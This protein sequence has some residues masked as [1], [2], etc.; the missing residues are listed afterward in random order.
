LL[1]SLS[2][3]IATPPQKIGGSAAAQRGPERNIFAR[4]RRHFPGRVFKSRQLPSLP[5]ADDRKTKS[6]EAD[7]DRTRH[8]AGASGPGEVRAAGLIY[9]KWP[10][11]NIR[12]PPG[13]KI[14]CF[15]KCPSAPVIL[16]FALVSRA[17]ESKLLFRQR[18]K[19]VVAGRAHVPYP[20]PR[21]CRLGSLSK[22]DSDQAR[23]QQD[24]T[25]NGHGE[26]TIRGEFF[27]H[28]APP[29]A[30]ECWLP[31]RPIARPT[32]R[33]RLSRCTVKEISTLFRRSESN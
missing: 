11:G 30:R 22:C 27:T 31:S 33:G 24:K 14:A 8:H 6:P 2:F 28:G 16:N 20:I 9:M 4:R 15:R 32:R 5:Y 10:P 29:I 19:E 13:L 18:N 12:R 23:A 3:R 21:I 1:N 26:E 7:L 25:C 17:G